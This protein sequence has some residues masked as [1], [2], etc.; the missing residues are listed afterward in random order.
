MNARILKTKDWN[1]HSHRAFIRSGCLNVASVC[2]P[3]GGPS[4]RA[5]SHGCTT[6]AGGFWVFLVGPTSSFPQWVPDVPPCRMTDISF[7]TSRR[8]A[9]AQSVHSLESRHVFLKLL[10]LPLKL[11]DVLLLQK[12]SKVKLMFARILRRSEWIKTLWNQ[13]WFW[14]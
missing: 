10:L 9:K 8:R 5:S 6:A 13:S 12:R 7:V 11:C 3:L 1:T 4:C 2:V 14:S